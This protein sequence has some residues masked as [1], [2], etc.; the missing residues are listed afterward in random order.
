LEVS[1]NKLALAACVVTLLSVASALSQNAPPGNPT[2]TGFMGQQPGDR[3]ASRLVGLN[4]QNAGNENIGEIYDIILTDAGAV[5]A[6]IVSVGG[7]LGMGTRY[8][9]I[10]PKAVTLTRQD[11]KTWKAAMNANKDQLRAAPEYKYE[12]EWRK[13]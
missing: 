4:I 11:E 8:V 2:N 1:V 7:F 13:R 6:Y 10:D 3:L 9:A 12:S 5:K